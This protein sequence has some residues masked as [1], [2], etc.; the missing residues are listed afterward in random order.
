M[1]YVSSFFKMLE[2][3]FEI[4]CSF[5]FLCNVQQAPQLDVQFAC[6]MPIFISADQLQKC[7]K[8]GA[9]KIPIYV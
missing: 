5:P 9:E 2:I 7:A 6:Q 3:A 4:I 8:R 1:Q